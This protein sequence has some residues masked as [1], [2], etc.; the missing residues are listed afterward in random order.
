MISHLFSALQHYTPSLST[1]RLTT[2]AIISKS[3]LN[4][5]VVVHVSVIAGVLELPLESS[6]KALMNYVGL[7][8]KSFQDLSQINSL[9]KHSIHLSKNNT[10]AACATSAYSNLI[11]FFT[12]MVGLARVELAT[13]RL[14]SVCSN[15]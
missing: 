9:P 11:Y 2:S 1:P 7:R 10:S 5:T 8:I 6:F 3:Y 13:P 15:H 4:C 12:S 14:S